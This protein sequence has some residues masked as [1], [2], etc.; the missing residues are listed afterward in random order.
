MSV[1]V[2]MSER[3]LKM[4]VLK[5]GLMIAMAIALLGFVASLIGGRDQQIAVS[6]LL[7]SVAFSFLANGVL[8]VFKIIDWLE[9]RRERQIHG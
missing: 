2:E 7:I 6:V 8:G 5:L 4:G 9:A 3:Q 1:I